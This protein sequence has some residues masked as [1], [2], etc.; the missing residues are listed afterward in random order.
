MN[1]NRFFPFRAS[2]NRAAVSL[3]IGMLL[4]AAH[5]YPQTADDFSDGDFSRNPAWSGDTAHFKVNAAMQLQLNSAG[6][7]TSALFLSGLAFPETEWRFWIKISFNTSANNHARV[8]L[9]VDSLSPP[10]LGDGYYLNAGGADDS[11]RIVR[12]QGS[13]EEILL[14]FGNYRTVHSTNLLRVVIRLTGQDDWTVM[15]DTAGGTNYLDAGSFR[16]PPPPG[17]F[18]FGLFCRYTSS[19]ATKICFDDVYLGPV[20]RDTLPPRVVS[21]TAETERRLAVR[22]SEPPDPASAAEKSH[23]LLLEPVLSVGS[24][25]PDPLNADRVILGLQ[26]PLPDGSRVRLQIREV[27]DPAGNRMADTVVEFF[28]YRPKPYD[29]L[30]HE[31]MA[32]PDPPAELPNGEYLEL[33]NRSGFPV[34]LAGWT[35]RY[36]SSV[37]TFPGVMVPANG[38][39]IVARDSAFVGYG[40]CMLL[41]SS[42]SSLSN[43]GTTVTLRDPKGALIH[44]VSYDPVWFGGS[45]KEE[46]G[47]SLEMKD[48]GNPCGCRENWAPSVDPAGGTP[49]RA[50]S[51][52]EP[53]PDADPPFLRRAFPAD[54]VTVDA[55]FTEPVD[56]ASA[57]R[58]EAWTLSGPEESIHPVEVSPAGPSFERVRLTFGTPLLPGTAFFL[59][60]SGTIPDCAANPSDTSRLARVAL[61]VRAEP[62][63]AVIN[64]ILPDPVPGGVR[65]AE[66][67]NRSG[68]VLDLSGLVLATGLAP[69]EWKTSAEPL[70]CEGFLF[71]PGDLVAFTPDPADLSYRYFS[72]IPLNLEKMNAF[73]VLGSDTGHLVLARKEDLAMIDSA[74]YGASMHYPLLVSR[75]GVSLE[76]TSPDISSTAPGNWHSA[77]ETAGFATPGRFNSHRMMPEP[78][79]EWLTAEPPVFSPGNDGNGDLLAVTLRT[80]GPGWMAG[81]RIYDATGRL[82]RR[83]AGE[84]M[85]GAVQTFFWDGITENGDRAPVGFCVIRAERVG[86][87]GKT[88]RVKKTV[89]VAP[90]R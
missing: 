64:E 22:F 33:F 40:P 86:P 31:I 77:A 55:W 6:S 1:S 17:R 71:F 90:G 42:S 50:N 75:E 45:F 39:L 72:A 58:T 67:C 2:F 56:S 38:F 74:V 48:P 44:S 78:G 52:E 63:D 30:I 68:K 26:D 23:Y 21:A 14:T 8:L 36:G 46:G 57:S 81:V 16:S 47:W 13:I 11:V 19:N 69:G 87:E 12:R 29:V 25:G 32:D 65:F 70:T 35:L 7:D 83:L 66:L 41:F 20:V 3:L 4:A 51:V 62:G 49:G 76:R 34:D 61:P 15:A 9:A 37:R 89:V 10:G 82:L 85:A 59:L 79:E 54:S 43:E 18:R 53:V 28:H 84:V 88:E 80:P 5:A 73:P 60:V 27:T 24:A